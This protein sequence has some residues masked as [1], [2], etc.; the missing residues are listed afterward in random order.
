MSDA[1]QAASGEFLTNIRISGKWRLGLVLAVTLILWAAA[2]SAIPIALESFS[3]GH[4]AVA[5]QILSAA[6]TFPAVLFLWRRELWPALRKN[7]FLVLV[8]GLT[9]IT[10]YH[11]ALGAG[12][13]TVG[14]GAASLLI[15]LG[16][17]VTALLAAS[18]LKERLTLRLVVGGLVAFLGASVLILTRN[19]D[20]GIDWNAML[21][22]LAM[23]LQSF[24]FILQRKLSFRYSAVALAV[25][26]IWIGTIALLPWGSG[27]TEAIALASTRSIWALVF[28]GCTCGVFPYIGWAFVISRVPASQASV[29]LYLIPPL[30]ILIGW[31]VLNETPTLWLLASGT[32]ILVGVVIAKS[33]PRK[34][35]A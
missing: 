30:S 34:S 21:V 35:V 6:V 27:V 16:P 25:L 29:W 1:V 20:L 14:A 22:V 4:L 3:P 12:Q 18:I 23:L 13:R 17:M 11:L 7:F 26:T 10:F 33:K 32:V 31:L 5:R 24:Y 28:L 15:N 19:G 9:G 8:M 2:F